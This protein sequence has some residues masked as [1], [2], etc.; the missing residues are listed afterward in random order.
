MGTGTDMGSYSQT[1]VTLH[2]TYTHRHRLHHYTN[3]HNYQDYPG[4]KVAQDLNCPL[5]I[6]ITL[7]KYDSSMLIVSV[8][9]LG[10]K[11]KRIYFMQ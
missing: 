9:F 6:L 7:L 1:M 4:S 3:K 2:I 10:E 5:L 8:D 11:T